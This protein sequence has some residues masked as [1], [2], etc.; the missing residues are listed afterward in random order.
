[1]VPHGSID[2]GHHI[3][4]LVRSQQRQNTL[5]LF[6]TI[7]LSREQLVQKQCGHLSQ[8]GKLAA[9]LFE[10]SLAVFGW[11]MRGFLLLLTRLSDDQ[12]VL[13]QLLDVSVVGE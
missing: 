1:M 13:G 5:C 3:G 10:L 4:M 7:A 9:Q 12:G 11:S 2:G 6:Q 8:S